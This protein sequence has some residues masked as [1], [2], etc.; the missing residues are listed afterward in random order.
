MPTQ[1]SHA[2][3]FRFLKIFIAFCTVNRMEISM[4]EMDVNYFSTVLCRRQNM[5]ILM[6]EHS[7]PV[8]NDGLNI[9]Y[10]LHGFSDDYKSFLQCS[11][12]ARYF[13]GMPVCIAIPNAQNSFYTDK[14]FGGRYETHIFSEIPEII[15]KTY[16]INANKVFVGGISMG[17]YG[18]VKWMLKSPSFFSAVFL[19]SPLTDI[20]CVADDDLSDTCDFSTEQFALG[21]IFDLN[22]LKQSEHDLVHQ[23]KNTNNIL[24]PVNIYCGKQ[25]FLYEKIVEFESIIKNKT[26][27][28]TFTQTEGKHKWDTW[29]DYLKDI[30]V[31]I[32]EII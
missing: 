21:N 30:A 8:P 15:N 6:P 29:E 9:L 3:T 10:L 16:N 27:S 13:D 22:L 28:C 17:G 32:S 26:K 19:V 12:V 1:G 31:K 7:V 11:A 20:V 18:A 24:P 4:I 14:I 2:K 23:V 25:D 5:C